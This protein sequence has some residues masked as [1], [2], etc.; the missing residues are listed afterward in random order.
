MPVQLYFGM[1]EHA[2]TTK[3]WLFSPCVNSLRRKRCSLL[4]FVSGFFALSG[5]ASQDLPVCECPVSVRSASCVRSLRVSH[6]VGRF[7]RA[8]Q[9]APFDHRPDLE[10]GKIN[11]YAANFV[12]YSAM[13]CEKL[14]K[15]QLIG[16]F[17]RFLQHF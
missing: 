4:R 1:A 2:Y 12:V 10:Y 6:H 8:W 7:L 14:K 16:I 17:G 11:R 3:K 15:L 5:A 13:Q 9:C